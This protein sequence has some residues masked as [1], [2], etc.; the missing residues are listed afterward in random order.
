MKKAYQRAHTEIVPTQ[1]GML[2]IPTV[3]PNE[4]NFPAPNRNHWVPGRGKSYRPP[5]K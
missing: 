3:S 2:M 1:S 4:P 5:H